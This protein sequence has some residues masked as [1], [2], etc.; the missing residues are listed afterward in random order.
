MKLRARHALAALLLLLRAAAFA[1]D[2][3]YGPAGAPTAVP[4]SQDHGYLSDPA[5]PAPDYW[6]LS[7]FYVPQANAYSCSVAA[8][9]MALN[10]LLN[11]GRS[12][13]DLDKNITE[14]EL[15]KKVKGNWK[16]LVSP[17]GAAGRHG[18]T[19]AQLESFLK[20][21]LLAYGAA[22]FVVEKHEAAGDTEQ[23]LQVLRADLA[24]NEKS[25]DDLML[26][27]FVQDDLTQAKGG[28]YPHVSPVGA[29][30]AA[31]RRVL[32]FD[33]DR[34]WYE[35]YWV[36]DRALLKAMAHPTAAFGRG[37]YIR[38]GRDLGKMQ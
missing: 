21:G 22:G 28:P 34:E 9:A 4:L 14:A 32:I 35:P 18:V 3:K 24:W 26:V 38:V 13:G 25:P 23:E 19:L 27:H 15:L 10:A 6:R 30:D 29:Y 36:P 11:T 33:V 17:A 5:H 2:P 12:R 37:G 20:A 8:V 7:S 16:G 31:R 1:A